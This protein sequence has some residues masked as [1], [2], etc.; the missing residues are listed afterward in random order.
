[1]RVKVNKIVETDG[2]VTTPETETIIGVI[3][4]GSYFILDTA[5]LNTK[6]EIQRVHT[7]EG[8]FVN[9]FPTA[10]LWELKW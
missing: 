10:N 8:V 5:G 7:E 1:M 6:N 2:N 9:N 4:S 3:R